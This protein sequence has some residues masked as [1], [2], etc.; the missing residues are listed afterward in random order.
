MRLAALLAI[1][2]VIGSAG[3]APAQTGDERAFIALRATHIGALTPMMT[4][5]M[6]SR[7]LNG[8]Q[9]GI[10]YGLRDEAGLR[11]QSV[12]GSGIIGVGMSSSVS[13]TAGVSDA[14]CFGCSPAMLLGFGGDVRVFEAGDAF[15]SGSTLSI[16][17]GGDL[18]Y[19]QLKPGDASVLALGVSAPVTLVLGATQEGMRIAPYFTPV[20]GIGS[21]STGCPT[22]LTP[23]EESGTRWVLGGGIGVWNPL[24][25]IAVS[26]GVNQVVFSSARPVLGVNVQIGG[27]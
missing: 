17:V 12:A 20:F 11:T 1:T 4:P 6:I 5:A 26:I 25:S 27:R 8:A 16:A 24:S 14:D 2:L 3:L 7:R 15:V 21:T 18:G 19:A 10:R 22:N 13:L 9:L 23:C